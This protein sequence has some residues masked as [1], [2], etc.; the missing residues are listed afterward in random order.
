VLDIVNPI[1]QR[2][3]KLV[4]TATAGTAVT[5]TAVVIVN[6]NG[7]YAIKAWTVQ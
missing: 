2:T 5:S 6:Q 3:F 4:S 1:V 7:A